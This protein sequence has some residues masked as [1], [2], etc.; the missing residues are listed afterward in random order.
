M[1][2]SW[3]KWALYDVASR[4]IGDYV[5]QNSKPE[6]ICLL[7][8]AEQEKHFAGVAL[9]GLVGL[10]RAQLVSDILR[11]D[12][13]VSVSYTEAP[14]GDLDGLTEEEKS[15]VDVGPKV[16][17]CVECKSLRLCATAIY[18]VN[19]P[20]MIMTEDTTQAPPWGFIL[21]P[22]RSQHYQRYDADIV[23]KRIT[24]ERIEFA[25][26]EVLNFKHKYSNLKVAH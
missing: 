3:D 1:S 26:G 8:N 14:I 22:F 19:K 18:I 16:L 15:Y 20:L 13:A 10:K 4:M 5:A 9:K 6:P 11:M 25:N 7:W 21:S 23:V 17:A 12:V 24:N 2:S